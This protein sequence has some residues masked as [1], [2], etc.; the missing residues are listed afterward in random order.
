MY[1][2]HNT[3]YCTGFTGFAFKNLTGDGLAVGTRAVAGPSVTVEK[4][5]DRSQLQETTEKT[6]SY[7]ACEFPY[8]FVVCA[9]LYM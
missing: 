2:N 4:E 1:L 6:S 9:I 3:F 5:Q 8:L 7:H